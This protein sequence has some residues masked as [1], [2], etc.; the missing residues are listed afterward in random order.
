MA[1]GDAV[2]L[3]EQVVRRF[4]PND[5][6]RCTIDE[7]GRPSRLKSY[8]FKWDLDD[9]GDP[10]RKECSVYQQTKLFEVRLGVFDCVE[11][12]NPGWSVAT[13]SVAEITTFTRASTDSPNPFD[14]VD[15]PFPNGEPAA[16]ARDG[17]HANIVH[18]HPLRGP[19]GW[20]RDLALKFR[21]VPRA[22]LG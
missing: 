5:E 8:A 19:D 16:H 15:A 4:D 17:A 21:P 7:A 3:D 12:V 9:E 14:V 22:S 2:S 6:R 18:P 13:A 11:E 10:T 20:Y 1:S